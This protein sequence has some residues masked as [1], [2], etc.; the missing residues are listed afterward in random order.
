MRQDRWLLP[1]GIEELLPAEAWRQEQMRRR[2]LDLFDT[3]GY[4]LVVPP[5]IEYL[6]A[7][8]TG[9]GEQLDLQT[10]KLTDQISGRLMGIRP[11]MT[12]Q[13][14]RIDAH[15]LKREVPTR[16][17]YL[18][19]VL[20]T[21]PDE[22]AG[23]REPLQMGAE[24]F[25]HRGA[26]SDVEIL[27]LM[28]ATLDL[29]GAPAVHVELGHVGVFRGLV[30]DAG[31]ET[32]Q[33]CE[34]FDALQRKARSEVQAILQAWSLPAKHKQALLALLDLNGGSEVLAHAQQHYAKS[35]AAVRQALDELQQVVELM[36]QY[37]PQQVLN[38]DFAELSGYDYYTGV[39]FAAYLPGH[40]RAV[41]KGGRYDGIGRSF[42]RD[43]P[44]TGFSAD[45][46]QLLKLLPTEV[47]PV[48]GILA[49]QGHD[50][51]LLQAISKLRAQGERVIMA[52]PDDQAS[53]AVLSCDR[54]LRREGDAWV[55]QAINDNE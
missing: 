29:I 44:A 15:Y 32:N 17:C 41:A 9:V 12:P 22:F 5:L 10:F 34:L 13:A 37:V 19:I 40:G 26:A 55:V 33:V 27:R 51:A 20:H 30:A 14:A 8:L 35:A 45:L 49:P 2:V 54:C 7:L 46:R 18:G 25:G 6:E 39:R 42:G 52:L 43:R 53:P 24:L 36:G 50:S 11:D 38:F 4:E 28:L 3:W 21:R 31:L 47:P 1:E 23:S 16:L 48:P